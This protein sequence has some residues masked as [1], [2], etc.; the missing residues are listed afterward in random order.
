MKYELLVGGKALYELDHFEDF[1]SV[2][3]M[4]LG[5]ELQK[6]KTKTSKWS[7]VYIFSKRR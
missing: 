4:R 3:R 2:F 7:S 6:M 1:M 5:E